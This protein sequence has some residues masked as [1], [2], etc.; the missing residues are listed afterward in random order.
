MQIPLLLCYN[1]YIPKLGV[2]QGWQFIPSLFF[3]GKIEEGV[4]LPNVDKNYNQL[5][6]QLQM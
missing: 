2:S 5:K 1:Y 4:F 3:C 6:N